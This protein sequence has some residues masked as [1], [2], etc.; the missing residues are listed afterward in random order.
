[1]VSCVCVCFFFPVHPSVM[2]SVASAFQDF[3]SL[4]SESC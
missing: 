2:K 4:V 1:M 3:F